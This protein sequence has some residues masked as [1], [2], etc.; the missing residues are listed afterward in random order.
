MLKRINILSLLQARESLSDSALEAFLG[1]YEIEIKKAEMMDLSVFAAEMRTLDD[2]RIVQFD[3]FY[4][5]YKIPQIG[6]EFDL[7]KFGIDSI[8]NVELKNECAEEQILAQLL[9]NKYYLSFIGRTVFAF[10][11]VSKTKTLYFLS[12]HGQL[13]IFDL[14]PVARTNF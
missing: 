14:R 6:K 1:Y 7:L 5:G 13:E 11:F 8:I 2:F 4:I 12:E 10:T 9:R 3:N